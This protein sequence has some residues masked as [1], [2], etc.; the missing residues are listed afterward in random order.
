MGCDIPVRAA[1][2][3]G[4]LRYCHFLETLHALAGRVAGVLLP[5][6]VGALRFFRA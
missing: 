3:G 1:R 5:L 2:P 6:E 4:P